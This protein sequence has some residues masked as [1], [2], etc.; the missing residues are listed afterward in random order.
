MN[1]QLFI[2]FLKVGAFTFGGG[3]AMIGL[4]EK[5]VVDRHRW[6]TKEQFLDAVALAQAMPG[7]FAANIATIVAERSLPLTPS[8]RGGMWLRSLSSVAGV[9]LPSVVVILLIAM[10]FQQFKDNVYVEKVFMGIRPCV[11]ALIAAPCFTLAKSA[12]LTWRNAWIPI[13]ACILISAFG[14]SPIIIIGV[15]ILLGFLFSNKSHIH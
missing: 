11:V 9:A 3:Y 10:F 14:V 7:L 4:I 13:L 2:T 8:H 5:E 15:T 6:L 1:R 12:G